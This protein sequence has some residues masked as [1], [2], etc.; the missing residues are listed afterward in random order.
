MVAHRFYLCAIGQAVELVTEVYRDL[1]AVGEGCLLNISIRCEKS[2]VGH[3]GVADGTGNG[4]DIFIALSKA[5][6]V[7]LPY[8][9]VEHEHRRRSVENIEKVSLVPQGRQ[10]VIVIAPVPLSHYAVV[11]DELPEGQ[12]V[13][14]S[15]LK[16]GDGL[17]DLIPGLNHVSPRVRYAIRSETQHSLEVMN[18]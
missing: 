6:F 9:A 18:V 13:L 15:Y 11:V 17:R 16:L 14:L 5:G 10:L 1:Y 8:P 12:A 3:L 2:V 4:T 7:L